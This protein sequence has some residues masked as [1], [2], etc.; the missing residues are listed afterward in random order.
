MKKINLNIA[1]FNILCE[2]EEAEQRYHG[3]KFL[4]ML[5]N[6]YSGFISKTVKRPDF[7]IDIFTTNVISFEI[8]PQ[9]TDKNTKNFNFTQFHIN[10][11]TRIL[12]AHNPLGS[13][14][15]E[16]VVNEIMYHNLLPFNK[17]LVLHGS[18]IAYK[19]KS[20]IFEGVPGAGKSTTAQL[21]RGLCNILSDDSLIVRKINNKFYSYSPIFHEK[22]F[23]FEKTG[24]AYLLNKVFFIKKADKCEIKEIKDK[25]FLLQKIIG[26][27][28]TYDKKVNFQFP[29]ITEFVNKTDFYY[30][31][32]KKDEKVFKQFFKKEILGI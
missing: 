2:I 13:F 27:V 30:L 17:G 14:D 3:E 29:L 4:E 19:D 11:K 26:Q 32:V 31:Y 24:E 23:N 22:N 28:F 25:N 18:S 10:E 12:S 9:R 1:G 7:T 15:F 20:F 21:L 16:S 6:N 5:T 8:K